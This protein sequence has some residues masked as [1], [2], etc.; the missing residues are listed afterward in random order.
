MNKITTLACAALLLTMAACSTKQ[1]PYVVDAPRNQAMPIANTYGNTL[2]PGDKLYIHIDAPS[3]EAVLPFNQETNRHA[4]TDIASVSKVDHEP[5]GYIVST[6]G[7]IVMPVIGRIH[8]AGMTTEQLADTIEAA[9]VRGGYV[10]KPWATVKLMNFE[11]SV[12]GE[13]KRPSTITSPSERLTIFE[14]IA[15]CGDVTMYGIR[16]CV[17]II[18]T[19][20]NIQTVDTVD[21]TSREVLNSPYYYLKQNDI[22]YVEPNKKRKRQAYSD[23]DWIRYTTTGL[24]TLQTAYLI[25]FRYIRLNQR[26]RL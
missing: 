14:A 4:I 16:S 10:N 15:M 6:T 2:S 24:S 26:G 21:L 23:A 7:Y 11:V 19:V 8:A 22:V 1:V 12:I 18:R 17:T 25:V 5:D 13:V 20:D 3:P 9:I